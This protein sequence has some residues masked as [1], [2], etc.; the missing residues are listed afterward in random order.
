MSCVIMSDDDSDDD[1]GPT[2]NLRKGQGYSKAHAS[3]GH[4]MWHFHITK[5]LTLL[6]LQ[7]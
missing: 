3:A 4:G 6:F 5:I 7:T 1:R 2:L